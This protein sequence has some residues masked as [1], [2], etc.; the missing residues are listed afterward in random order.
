MAAVFDLD[1]AQGARASQMVD[2]GLTAIQTAVAPLHPKAA[3]AELG[4]VRRFVAGLEASVLAEV[5]PAD[6]NTSRAERLAGDA[7]TS[8]RETRRRAKRGKA[9]A[10]SGGKLA[11]KLAS[12]EL[13]EEQADLI[14]DA[15]DKSDG[16][17]A[18]DDDFID[19]IAGADPDQGRKIRDDWLDKRRSKDD[20]DTEHKRQ[21]R[22]RH[23]KTYTS[24]R[25]GLGVVSLHGD[26][27]ARQLMNDA[28]KQRADEIYRRDGG[29]DLPAH[30]HPRTRAQREF[31]AAYELICGLTTHPHGTSHAPPEPADDPHDHPAPGDDPAPAPVDD[32]TPAGAAATSPAGSTTARPAGC[33]CGRSA[34]IARREPAR[35]SIVI[36]WTIDGLV[37]IDPETMATQI[38]LGLIPD[39]VLADYAEHGDIIAA[40]YDTNGDQLWQGRLNRYATASQFIALVIRD[41]GCV[42]CGAPHT[43]CDA[44]HLT[45]WNAP[46]RGRTDLDKMALLCKSCHTR[47]HADNHTLYRDSHTGLWNTRPA[48]AAETPPQPIPR[49]G[50]G[51]DPP[52]E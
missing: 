51:H 46:A 48:T 49:P 6:G 45:P 42:L 41:R 25:D 39:S 52:R 3:L 5:V 27:I 33:G 36:A 50:R 12:G 43:Q 28:I 34:A 38:G 19:R 26:S 21:R 7:K 37:G 24:K 20:V 23:T 16:E 11:D 32:A 9:N 17:A 47:L 30:Q 15:S 1:Q 2:V 4:R 29:R 44:H 18:N 10:A 13:S 14:A 40:L 22:L 31:D 35:P 8:K